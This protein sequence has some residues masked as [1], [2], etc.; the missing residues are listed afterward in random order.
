MT[1]SRFFSLAVCVLMSTPGLAL[2]GF[3]IDLQ[4]IDAVPTV[5]A[6]AII[7]AP[8]ERLWALIDR[9]ADYKDTM[10]SIVASRELWRRDNKRS[11]DITADLPFPLPDLRGTTEAINTI[12]PGKRW[13]R[14]WH[15][16]EGDYAVNNGS[17]T[18][19]RVDRPHARGVHARGETQNRDPCLRHPHRPTQNHPRIIRE[20]GTTRP[21]ARRLSA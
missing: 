14:A 2:E 10:V 21:R 8:A 19:T 3:K 20:A 18:L 13:R 5:T 6:E 1:K 7:A 4:E 11:C 15:L 12:D 16:T 9:C 17:W